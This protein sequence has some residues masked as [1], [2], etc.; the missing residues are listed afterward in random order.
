M[1][2]E[3]FEDKG[4]SHYSYA[5]GCPGAGEVAIVDP[6]RDIDGYLAYAAREGL[7]IAYVLETHI[8]ACLLYTSWCRPPASR[9]SWPSC[10]LA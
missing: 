10:P 7:R 4:L 3:R 6:R 1:I 9:R 8:H 2:L 5:V